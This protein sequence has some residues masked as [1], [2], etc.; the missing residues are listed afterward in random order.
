MRT[1]L[2]IVLS[3]VGGLLLLVG[4]AV[5]VVVG[6]DDT[7]SLPADEVPSPSGV[8]LTAFDMFPVRDLTLHVEAT[9][10]GGPVFLG[11]AHPVDGRDYVRGVAASWVRGV[12]RTGTLR[13]DAIEG[14]LDAPEVDPTAA[15]FWTDSA[16]GDGTQALD[17]RLADEPVSFVVAPQGGPAATTLAFGVL[18]PRSFVAAL[19][20]AAVGALL[21]AGAVLVRR[22]RVR[23]EGPPAVA[24]SRAGT[25]T[26]PE[27]EPVGATRPA[28]ARPTFTRT[29]VLG[30][31]VAVALTACTPL[32]SAVE[33]PSA[34]ARIAADEDEIAAALASYGERR[35]AASALASQLDASGWAASD[36]DGLLALLQFRTTLAAARGEAPTATT[37]TY[38]ALDAAV[39][40]FTSYPM[41]FV[42]LL[43]PTT[44]G[45]PGENP[46]IRVFERDRATAPWRAS[47]ALEVPADTVALPAPGAASVATP[48]QVA[49][50]LAGVELLRSHLETGAEVGVELGE[51][52]DARGSFLGNDLEG[53][54]VVDLAQVTV[55]G[56]PEDPTAPGGPVQVVPVDGGVLVTS[57]LS[58]T[59]NQRMEAGWTV[60]LTDDALAQATGQTGERQNIRA[61]GVVQSVLLV[62]DDTAPRVLAAS[63]SFLAP[64][65]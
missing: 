27:P 1:F 23:T 36:T 26:G 45:T 62:P 28:A 54:L 4:G 7:A 3:A 17:V 20:V 64:S 46:Q 51:L 52:A 21:V 39:P 10:A 57:T 34:P 40:Q 22:R 35:T 59:F 37:V 53:K 9:S 29:A 38:S 49:A 5:A 65:A 24:T 19:G 63:W 41:W 58:L 33:H 13:T 18:V 32:P 15:T 60:S 47:L 11:T 61:S 8:A 50:G 48:E 44:D 14:E 56:A 12:D 42:A 2:T 25:S 6:P 43:E 55:F 31:G 16:S 30:A